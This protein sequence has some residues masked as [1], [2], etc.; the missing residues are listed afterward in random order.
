MK[1]ISTYGKGAFA[2]LLLSLVFFTT[3][4]FSQSAGDF[5]SAATGNWSAPATWQRFDGISWTPAGTAPDAIGAGVI[6]ILNPHVVTVNTVVNTDQTVVNVGGSLVVSSGTL[7]VSDGPGIDLAVNGSMTFSGSFIEGNGQFEVVS[8]GTFIWTNGNMRGSGVTTFN[9]GSTVTLSTGGGSRIIGDTRIITN[10]GTVNWSSGTNALAFSNSVQFNNNGVFNISTNANFAIIGGA[11]APAFNNAPGSFLQKLDASTTTLPAPI[12]LNNSGAVNVNA[13][14]LNVSA[15]GSTQDGAYTIQGSAELTGAT[16]NYT[17]VAFSNSGQVSLNEVSFAGTTAQTLSGN[18][19]IQTMRI[20]NANGVTVSGTP[21]IYFNLHLTNG[22][23]TA[24]GT[25]RVITDAG[26]SVN[27]ASPSS[28]I[29][30]NMQRNISVPGPISFAVGDANAYAPVTLDPSFTVAGNVTV[31]ALPGDHA[32]ISTSGINPSKSVN[33]TW[34]ITNNSLTFSQC[35]V[36]FNWDASVDVDGGANF[37]NFILGQY[38]APNWSLPTVSN[39]TGNSLSVLDLPSFGQYQVGEPQPGSALNFDGVNDYVQMPDFNLGTSNFTVE[40]WIKPVGGSIGYIIT[41]R[42][43]EYGGEGNWWDLQLQANNVIGIEMAAAGSQNFSFLPGNTPLTTGVWSHVAVVRN[44]TEILLYVNGTLDAD[45]SDS[46]VRNLTTGADIGRLGGWANPGL[47]WYNGSMDEVRVWHAAL[48]SSQIAA[49]MNCEISGPVPSLFSDYHFNQGI[50]GNTNSSETTLNDASG[51]SINGTLNDFALSGAT[52]NWVA[53]GGVVSGNSCAPLCIDADYPTVA[54]HVICAGSSAT[55]TIIAGN[56]NSATFWHWYEGNCEGADA[57]TGTSINVSPATTTTYFVRAEGGCVSPATCTSVEVT[58]NSAPTV[59]AFSD[60]TVC[61][62]TTTTA[63]NFTGS[64]TGGRYYWTNDDPSIGLAASGTGDISSFTAINTNP[65]SHTATIT[66]TPV[67]VGYAYVANSGSNDVSVIDRGNNTVSATIPVGST[68][69]AVAASADGQRVYVGNYN[70]NSV[71]VINTSDNSIVTTVSVGSQPVG[72]TISPNDQN[73]YVANESGNSVSVIHTDDFSNYNV[74]AT[75]PVGNTPFGIVVSPDGSH[76]YVTNYN[77]NDV[78]V[79]NAATNTV[80]ATVS[81]GNSPKE[82]TISHDGSKVYVVNY[83]S[84]GL[85][86]V[87]NTSD[88]S[89]SPLNVG[90]GGGPQSITISPD[91]SRLYVA[92]GGYNNVFVLDASTGAGI[93][94]FAA[95]SN[96]IG[97]AI[98][99]DGSELITTNIADNSVSVI[100]TSNGSSITVPVGTS[101]MSFGNFI[102]ATGCSGTSQSATVTVNAIPTADPQVLSNPVCTTD[103]IQLIGAP[104]GM[105]SYS[106]SGPADFSSSEQNP[107]IGSISTDNEG[108]YTLTVTAENG[109]AGNPASVHVDVTVATTWYIDSD[110]DGYGDATMTQDACSQPSGYV[111]DHTDCDDNNGSIHSCAAAALNFDGTDDHVSFPSYPSYT[112][113]SLTIEAWINAP[114]AALGDDRDIVSWEAADA[115]IEFRL[116]PAGNLQFLMYDG[117]DVQVVEGAANLADGNWYHVAMV[118]SGTNVTLYV[119]GTVEATGTITNSFAPDRFYIGRGGFTKYFMGNIDEVRIWNVVRSQAEIQANMNCEIPVQSGLAAAY[120]FN[121]GTAYGDNSSETTLVDAALG[122]SGSLNNFALNGAVSNWVAPGGVTTG[123]SCETPLS[124]PASALNFDGVDDVGE[125]TGYLVPV[126]NSPYTVS[127]WAKQDAFLSGTWR[128]I[129]AQ[130]RYLYVGPSSIGDIRVGDYWL[131]SGVPF[132]TDLNYHNYTVVRTTDNTYL[133]LDGTLAATLGWAIPSPETTGEPGTTNFYIGTQWW[134]NNQHAES[135]NGDID[136]LRVWS[137]ALSALEISNNLNC[138]ITSATNGLVADYH[139]NQGNAGGN[140]SSQ[141]IVHDNSGHEHDITLYN[142]ALSGNGSNWVDAAA[143]AT[144]SSC[145]VTC[146]IQLTYASN[147]ACNEDPSV[148]SIDLTSSNATEPVSYSWS[149]AATTEDISNLT[150]GTYDVTVTDNNGCSATASIV[151]TQIQCFETPID[152]P[153]SGGS[154]SSTGSELGSLYTNPPASTDTTVVPVNDDGFVYIDVIPNSGYYDTVLALIQSDDYGMTDPIIDDTTLVITGFYPIAHIPALDT[155]HIHG[156]LNFSRVSI[157]PFLSVSGLFNSGGDSAQVSDVTRKIYNLNGEGIKVGVLSDSYNKS[158]GDPASLDISRGDLPGSTPG[159]TPVW[160]M[161]DY[162]YGAASDEGRAMLQIIYDIAPKATLDFRTG[163]VSPADFALGI[164]ELAADGCN[165]IVDD[166]TYPTEPFF[167]DG[168]VANAVNDVTAQ[169]ISY[170]TAAGNFGARSYSGVF[171]GAGAGDQVHQFGIDSGGNPDTLQSLVLPPGRYTFVLQWDNDFYSLNQLPGAA[172]DLDIFIVNSNGTKIGYNRKNNWGDPIEVLNFIVKGTTPVST[173]VMIRRP[174]GSTANLKFKYIVFRGSPT[175]MEYAT[176]GTSTI[177]GQANAEGA[178]TVGATRYTQTPAFGVTPP[179][180]ESFTSTGGHLINGSDRH[181]PDFTAPDGGNSSVSF[182]ALVDPELDSKPNFFGTSAA[183]PHAAAVAALIQQAKSRFTG[184]FASPSEMRAMLKSTAV[185]IGPAGDDV[186]SGSGLIQADLAIKSFANP[187]PVLSSMNHDSDPAAIPGL[188]TVTV[189][190]YGKYFASGA[191]LTL[192]HIPVPTTVI[193]ET[194]LIAV[195]PSFVGNPAVQVY[196]PPRAISGADGGYSD[197]LYFNESIHHTFEITAHDVTK[198]YGEKVPDLSYSITIDGMPIEYTSLSLT[199]LKL[200][201]ISVV[202]NATSSSITGYYYTR[203]VSALTLDPNNSSDAELLD[204]YTYHYNDGLFTINK[205]PLVIRPNNMSVSFGDKIDGRDMTY[206]FTFDQ[207]NIDASELSSFTSNLSSIYEGGVI[208]EIALLDDRTLVDGNSL[209]ASELANLAIMSGGRGVINGGRGVINGGRGVINHTDPDT[210]YVVDIDYASLKDYNDGDDE[211]TLQDSITI[212][213]GGRGVINGGRGVANGG[214][215]VINCQNLVD[216]DIIINGGRGVI[217]GGRGVANGGRGVANGGRGV[218]NSEELDGTSNTNTIVIVHETD[219]E[220]TDNPDSTFQLYTMNGVT[221]I[222]AGDHWI[223]PGGFL[224]ADFDVSYELG[225]LN[226]TKA[227]LTIVAD[228]KNGLCN[229]GQPVYTATVTGYQ[230]DDS[231][232]VAFNTMIYNIYDSGNNL[233]GSG[234][235]P[236]GYYSIGPDFQLESY[237][238]YV[239]TDVENGSLNVAPPLSVTASGSILCHDATATVHLTITGG[240][241]P[242]VSSSSTFYDQSP[243]EHTYTVTDFLGCTASVTITLV[244]PPA[245]A[246]TLTVTPANCYPGT[247]SIS[248]AASGGTPG[249]QYLW[250]NG[251]TNAVASG[252]ATGSYSVRVT[253]LN[254]CSSTF[255][256]TLT[257]PTAITATTSSTPALCSTGTGSVSVSPSGGTP[258]Y[259]YLWSAGSQT[260]AVATGLS[261][262]SYSVRVTDSHS[263]SQTF[264]VILTNPTAV[265]GTVTASSSVCGNNNGSASVAPSGGTPGYNYLWTGGY[266]TQSVSNLAAGNY[267]VR[268]TD[269]HSCSTTLNFVIGS[270]PSMTATTSQTNCTYWHSADGSASIAVSGGTAPFVYSWNTSPVQTTVTATGLNARTAPILGY[271][272]TVTDNRGCTVTKTVTITEPPYSCGNLNEFTDAEIGGWGAPPNGNNITNTW[273]YPYF[274]TVFPS[275]ITIGSAGRTLQFNCAQAITNFLPAAATSGQLPASY[276]NPVGGNNPS[277]PT[278][279]CGTLGPL[280]KNTLASK[281]L[282]LTLNVKFDE[283]IPTF[284][285]AFNVTYGDLVYTASPFAGWTV[286][287]ILAEANR[288]LGQGLTGSQTGTYYSTVESAITNIVAGSN[289][290]C[291]DNVGIRPEGDLPIL[292]ESMVVY[293]NPTSGDAMAR[294]IGTG[295][296]TTLEAYSMNGSVDIKLFDKM[297]E[298]GQEYKVDIKSSAWANGVYFIRLTTGENVTVQKLIIMNK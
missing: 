95:G 29:I 51:N 267:S 248:A 205:M 185:D 232:S 31:S 93:T 49:S 217:N 231:D 167:Q 41:N 196:N 54:S 99:A 227:P 266:T 276:V 131:H 28:Y 65:Y 13:G 216:G 168:L 20:N 190:V 64:P 164:R 6:T 162:P 265:T 27:F 285:A 295:E 122:A 69:I 53:P 149:N 208:K 80:S 237:A 66:V 239:V 224:S 25:S 228:D 68:P 84:Y 210:T 170:F 290:R 284:S 272:V 282:A 280:Y 247:G 42:S 221:G 103:D 219:M 148:G 249:Y 156:L 242:Y 159:S 165:I 97:L 140:N 83:N 1:L 144:G 137:R 225:T 105:T 130:G 254:S 115:S 116:R 180:T 81:V 206:T 158:Y 269:S 120:H 88:N 71:S 273:L 243:G 43:Y 143:V 292:L 294:F 146:E 263:C 142:M 124:T 46:F 189:D 107:L 230:Y 173:N 223:I 75:V 32:N 151:I 211:I 35:D 257:N 48:S 152:P 73:I 134:G 268:I 98:S 19:L 244:N 160:V 23:I 139:F 90:I 94:S 161:Q 125:Y 133:Y 52:S 291:P 102:S 199:D 187:A 171:T 3:S 82:L 188:E 5:R 96:T 11:V 229:G 240:T 128:E 297:V 178:M 126:G 286:K 67:N 150:A 155:L 193:D 106:W 129:F 250:S 9:G 145:P 47:Y 18:G 260:N 271:T 251:Q 255:T 147:N 110:N 44:G 55:L 166:I 172:D 258:G 15:F 195:V 209:A 174:W 104:S 100:N 92:G 194:H 22:K 40:A 278:I 85:I 283:K 163:F 8:G 218:I 118:K 111:A 63:I 233:M 4:V 181:K 183:A 238:N 57:G 123:N 182:G 212:L 275:G 281:T 136:E 108:D 222:T 270:S 201:Q 38:N 296:R 21:H 264:T 279:P 293:P 10:Y 235:L 16:L 33:R 89:V 153:A 192:R 215:G 76:V 117:A 298:Q 59:Y 198:K 77:S 30:G 157:R 119:N 138:E 175:S 214:R 45:Y 287:Q 220:V 179:T 7:Q 121:R 60:Q 12:A 202:T 236:Q 186:T 74:A 246:A 191:S 39:R 197:T 177:V 262:G 234:I 79:I 114:V 207:S 252:L 34:T 184:S 261:S 245:I 141:T 50:A 135:W 203:P 176:T 58:V 61:A 154:S 226:I 274:A 72:I 204:T 259:Q 213:N 113:G 70:S 87:I 289:E 288:L 17:G 24:T 277:Y 256:T 37:N 62:G 2:F 14:V 91:D 132:P 127:V 109:C 78:S 169:G 56:L 36:T 101:P 26:V 200:D 112:N 241:P 253:D 86:S